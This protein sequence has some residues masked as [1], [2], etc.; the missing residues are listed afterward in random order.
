MEA[1]PSVP[2]LGFALGVS[3]VTGVAAGAAPAWMVSRA[4]PVEALRGARRSAGG[5]RHWAQKALV[6]VQIA[7]SLV[8]L[9]TAGLLGR[10]VR[11]REHQDFGFDARGKYLVTI[12]PKLSN[13]AQERLTP[14][15]GEIEARL[16]AMAGVRAVGSAL[17][18]PMTGTWTQSVL[19]EGQGEPGPG[20]DLYAGWTRVT[21]GFF[22]AMGDRM[23]RGR[24]I[25][26]DDNASTRPVAVVNEAFAKK[27]LEDRIRLGSGLDRLRG[28]NAGMYEI[29]GVAA[30]VS[31][32]T[33][34][35]VYFLPEAQSTHF[36]KADV[37]GREVW[38]HYLYNIVIDAPGEYAA[39]QAE[40]KKSLADVDPNLVMYDVKS[41]AQIIE[42][43]FAQQNMI[44]VLTW[45]FGIAGLVLAAVGLYGVTA[46]GVE[47]RTNEIGV[48]MA[49]G[50]DRGAVVT[51]VL[52]GVFV[53][54]G[55]G[56][57]LGVPAAI[58]AGR[59]MAS[60]LFG[61]RPWEPTMLCGAAL[62]L[63]VAAG[64][65]G[66]IPARRAAHVEP[67]VALRQE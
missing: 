18:A 14:L 28:K 9:S 21:P 1:T 31:F 66:A 62:V 37:E 54:V 33:A 17:H 43:D 13:Y 53:Q 29:V 67:M 58:G 51:M 63:V 38:S 56:V 64:I 19:T 24:A 34:G 65:A 6:I 42:G 3:I 8:L 11:N 47:Q 32:G 55:V 48:R 23:V 59:M 46:Y 2:V 16:R 36:D 52:R 25:T 30:D 49:L 7:A 50:A 26:D 35:P 41:Y 45:L 40:V 60:Q 39:M 12:D 15:F 10:S 57:A 27:F 22:S 61:V 5:S 20:D 44:A 4:R